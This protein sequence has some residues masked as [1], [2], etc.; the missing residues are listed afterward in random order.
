MIEQA[1]LGALALG[2]FRSSQGPVGRA[3]VFKLPFIFRESDNA[4]GDRSGPDR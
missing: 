3:Q 1:Q 2:A 4:T